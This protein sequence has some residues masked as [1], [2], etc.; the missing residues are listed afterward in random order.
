MAE[1]NKIMF[2]VYITRPKEK[3]ESCS[4]L[5]TIRKLNEILLTPCLPMPHAALTEAPAKKRWED[6]E[7]IGVPKV[8]SYGAL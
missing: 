7:Y 2:F 5:G 6:N 8:L 4:T 1:P 3:I